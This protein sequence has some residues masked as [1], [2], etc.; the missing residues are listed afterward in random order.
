MFFHFKNPNITINIDKNKCA[1]AESTH[2]IIDGCSY[3]SN[4]YDLTENIDYWR[5]LEMKVVKKIHL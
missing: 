1:T 3:D 2:H 5:L 4:E